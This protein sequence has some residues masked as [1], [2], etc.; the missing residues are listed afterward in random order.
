MRPLFLFITFLLTFSGFAQENPYKVSQISLAEGLSQ[1][2]VYDIA[3]DDAGYLWFGT[4]DGLNRYDG[5]NFEIFKNEPFDTTSISSNQISSLLFDSKKRLWIG[6]HNHGLNLFIKKNRTFKVIY[7][8]GEERGAILNKSSI[9]CLFEDTR[10]IIWIG[11]PRGIVAIDN[12]NQITE[13]PVRTNDTDTL[14]VFVNSILQFNEDLLIATGKGLFL[15]NRQSDKLEYIS[16]LPYEK[17]D[18]QWIFTLAYDKTNNSIYAGTHTGLFKFTL[19]DRSIKNIQSLHYGNPVPVLSIK[20]ESVLVSIEGKGLFT[21]ALN[22]KDQ[23]TQLHVSLPNSIQSN[24]IKEIIT[25]HNDEI[26]NGMIWAGTSTKGV[27]KFNPVLKN[28]HTNRFQETK[29]SSSFVTAIIKDEN[30]NKWIGTPDGL[31]RLNPAGE[32]SHFE[33]ELEINKFKRNYVSSLAQDKKGRL[34]IGKVNGILYCDNPSTDKPVFKIANTTKNRTTEIIRSFYESR[35][36]E[37]FAV[38]KNSILQFNP[39]NNGFD[40]IITDPDSVVSNQPGYNL[41]CMLIDSK[42][43]MWIGTTSGLIKRRSN[44]QQI[45]YHKK[46]NTS[47]LRDHSI[48]HIYEDSKGNIWLSTTNGFSKITE[49]N[50]IYKITN[51]SSFD[52]LGNNFVYAILEDKNDGN[53]W[54]STN[55][56][57]TSFNPETNVFLTFNIHDGLQSNEFNSGAFSLSD[58]GEMYFGGID[59][60]TYFYP[61]EIKL[62]STP[63][64]VFISGFNIPGKEK[65]LIYFDEVNSI[66]KIDLKYFENS[67][68]VSFTALHFVNPLKN[69]YSY[70]L[71]G[72]QDDWIYSGT[73]NSI[74]FSQLPAGDY[75]LHVKAANSDGIYNEAGDTLLISISSPFWH[76]IWFYAI[77]FV[78]ICLI[79]LGLHRYRLSLKMQQVLAIDKIRKETAQDFHDEL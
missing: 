55:G 75:T 31:L 11:T 74:N 22:K 42:N 58:D 53:L 62:D 44:E 56:G 25:L 10:G 26:N 38:S 49:L 43:N 72:Y 28:F 32:Y 69:T 18:K 4:Q 29:L 33:K 70:K 66:K 21:I 76:T 63:P 78:F 73:L 50:G 57:L 51:Y 37:F 3:Q 39:V 19:N 7:G 20:N 5:I 15:L 9:R 12:E 46:D 61:S 23:L 60:Y 8:E 41:N 71:E 48:Q 54:I 24:E 17:I 65:R 79:L 1:S 36:G 47:S 13:Y 14:P 68:T 40:V 34:W 30:N 77:A 27:L 35:E 6:T 64:R 16:A 67:F 45:F 2:I 52:G 59:G